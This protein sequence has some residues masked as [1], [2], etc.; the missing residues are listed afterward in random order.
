MS[1]GSASMQREFLWA[2]WKVH[3]LSAARFGPVVG[4][5]ILRYLRTRG[6]DV[7]PGALYPLLRRMERRG[8]LECTSDRAIPS[9]ARHE[10]RI[11]AEGM[12]VFKEMRAEIMHLASILGVTDESEHG[13]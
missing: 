13:V 8:W 3:I 4:Q 11:T 10:Y 12:A 2:L 5:D 7:S 6:Y 9:R 1:S